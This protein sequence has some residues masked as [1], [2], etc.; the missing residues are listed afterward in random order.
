MFALNFVNLRQMLL[1]ML[2]KSLVL[3]F[4]LIQI[5]LKLI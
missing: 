4:M 1:M 2:L 3:R 5:L